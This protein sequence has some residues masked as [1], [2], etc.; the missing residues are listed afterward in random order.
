MTTRRPFHQT[1]THAALCGLLFLAL[2]ALGIAAT[3]ILEM[4]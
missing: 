1:H 2:L 3:L 4:P